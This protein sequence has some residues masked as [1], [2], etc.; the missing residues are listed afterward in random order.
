MSS[1][2]S[3]NECYTNMIMTTGGTTTG[4]GVPM[5]D[6]LSCYVKPHGLDS[7]THCGLVLKI[8]NLLLC[9]WCHSLHISTSILPYF[10]LLFQKV[11]CVCVCVCV[12]KGLQQIK[13]RIFTKL[14]YLC[15]RRETICLKG[16]IFR[17]V[18]TYS[19]DKFDCINRKKLPYIHIEI[20]SIMVYPNCTY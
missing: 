18:I 15:L 11:L 14:Q 3:V 8:L 7:S 19:S 16:L 13:W 6:W 1:Y 9:F 4:H 5:V 17:K 10:H 20:K 2:V 12:R